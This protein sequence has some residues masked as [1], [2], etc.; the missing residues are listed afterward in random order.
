MPNL[1]LEQARI[2]DPIATQVVHGYA[3]SASVANFVAPNVPVSLRAG[4][5]VQFTKENFLLVDTRRAPGTRMNRLSVGFSN[6]E[7]TVKQHAASAA[8]PFE[9]YEEAI[10]GARINLR[11]RAIVRTASAI[12][13]SWEQEV[14]S[15]I[16]DA[17]KYESACQEVAAGTRKFSDNA[18]DPEK[19]VED[20]AQ[21][22]RQQIGTRPNSAVITTDVY[23]ALRFH[24]IFRDRVKYTSEGSV[25]IEMLAKWL[26]FSRGIRVSDR[27]YAT[28][29]SAGLVDFMP[30][31]S[32]VA[33]FSPEGD[34]GEGFLPVDGADNAVPAAFYTYSLNG[35]PIAT[36]E[37]YDAD[38]GEFVTDLFA[39]QSI[40]PV[41]LGATG[42]IGAAFL[43]TALI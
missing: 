3:N 36:E 25:T 22:I 7:Y 30:A 4:K 42:K 32:M 40:Q 17:N 16:V 43:A 10:A 33:F 13:Q 28:G 37:R 15:M 39:E 9:Q 23:N 20:W 12:E 14:T 18:S 41:G 6:D 24:P 26:N 21:A 2:V 5:I 29:N 11:D 8:V 35:Y 34:I 38:T 19:I 31:G 1:S 27:V